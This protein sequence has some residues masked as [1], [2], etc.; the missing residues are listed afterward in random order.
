[1]LPTLAA[2]PGF[3]DLL[4][5]E[6]KIA[7]RLSHPNIVQIFDFGKI[8]RNYFIAMEAVEGKDLKSILQRQAKLGEHMPIRMACMITHQA[9]KGLHHAHE[10]SDSVGFP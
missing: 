8:D 2:R 7:A 9:A 6:A 10:R 1:M 5:R 4:I 3:A